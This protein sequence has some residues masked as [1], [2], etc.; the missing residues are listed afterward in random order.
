[1]ACAYDTQAMWIRLM[2]FA[3]WLAVGV[4]A[5]VWLMP[6]LGPASPAN[7]AGTLALAEQAPVPPADWSGLLSPAAPTAPPAR[8]GS[9]DPGLRLLGVAGPV[10]PSGQGVALLSVG[11]QAARA[12]KPGDAVDATR[13]VLE[14]TAH[15]VKIGPPDGAPGGAPRVTLEVPRLPPAATGVPSTGAAGASAGA[16]AGANAAA[17]PPPRP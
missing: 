7:R 15:T 6:W 11:G 8:A 5:V 9:D 10:R 2:T 14:V 4:S 17:A 1:M 13:V 16:G 12:F 3:L